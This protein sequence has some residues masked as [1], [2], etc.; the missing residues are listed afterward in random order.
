MVDRFPEAFE[1]FEQVVDI[2]SFRNYRVSLCF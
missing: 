1:K 2:R